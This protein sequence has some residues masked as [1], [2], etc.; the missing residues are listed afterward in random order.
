MGQRHSKVINPITKTTIVKVDGPRL[1][2][3]NQY[4]TVPAQEKVRVDQAKYLF[5]LAQ[6]VHRFPRLA[7][8]CT[9]GFVE[10]LWHQRPDLARV[11]I[12]ASILAE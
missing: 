2:A 7:R 6:P 4:I 10:S 9:E 1:A 11:Q 8:D 12:E 3:R 5:P